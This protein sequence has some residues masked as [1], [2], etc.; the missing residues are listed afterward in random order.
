MRALQPRN[1]PFWALGLLC[2]FVLLMPTRASAASDY[3]PWY[4][5]PGNGSKLYSADVEPMN[6]SNETEM[7]GDLTCVFKDGSTLDDQEKQMLDNIIANAALVYT[8][9][10][11]WRNDDSSALNDPYVKEAVAN[12]GGF[13]D[14][15]AGMQDFLKFEQEE[16]LDKDRWVPTGDSG[17][18]SGLLGN[19]D[20]DDDQSESHYQDGA[21]KST[22]E[23][24]VARFMG[25]PVDGNRGYI[26]VDIDEE[27]VD[28]WQDVKQGQISGLLN[29]DARNPLELYEHIPQGCIVGGFDSEVSFSFGDF[30]DE[31]ADFIA[32]LLVSLPNDLTDSIYQAAYPYAL[33]FT[34]WTPHSERGDTI[35]NVSFDCAPADNKVD[36]ISTSAQC[37]NGKPLGFD[38]RRA[39]PGGGQGWYLHLAYFFQ[40]LVS[41]FY[42]LLIAVAAVLYM[43]RGN[44]DTQMNVLKIVPR[45]LLSAVLTLFAP[46]IIGGLISM[47][48]FFVLTIFSL[49]DRDS[50]GYI[51]SVLS[52]AGAASGAVEFFQIFINSVTGVLASI[53]TLMLALYA[54]FRQLVL[55]ALVVF[56]PVA[57][58]CLI[59]DAWRPHFLRYVRA[60]L[61]VV[62]LPPA[63]ALFLKLALSINPLVASPNSTFGTTLG[64]LGV[65]MILATLW[66]T[67]KMV[68]SGVSAA[69]NSKSM[70]QNLGGLA[71][72][73]AAS[74]LRPGSDATG[75]FA[76]LRRLGAGAL[77]GAAAAAALSD[78]A[79]AKMVPPEKMAAALTPG[80]G[81]AGMKAS[82][83]GGGMLDKGVSAGGA[84]KA[85]LGQKIADWQ[86]ARAEKAAR[87]EF[88]QAAL[89]PQTREMKIPEI[90]QAAHTAQTMAAADGLDFN[91]L[92][93]KRQ[94]EYWNK[95][96]GGKIER[97][98][99]G[100]YHITPDDPASGYR[101]AE[102]ALPGGDGTVAPIA[103]P[104]ES[105]G[106]NYGQIAA[107]AAVAGAAGA[108]A[109]G[110]VHS[111]RRS[112][113]SEPVSDGAPAPA[114]PPP[115]A[116]DGSVAHY[117][118]IDAA[119]RA[120]EHSEAQLAASK[121]TAEGIGRMAEQQEETRK[122]LE[123]HTRMHKEGYEE[124]GRHRRR[125]SD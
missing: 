72:G 74:R 97:R 49:D 121:E 30:F 73:A 99:D 88:G 27:N 91:K 66:M 13:R 14:G 61:I 34:F 98:D 76:S 11:E 110:A 26:N 104:I 57:A 40:W 118:S 90:A 120:R 46:F 19:L 111:A 69:Y 48:N 2:V 109:S 12:N 25:R 92:S 122:E 35:L 15:Q 93:R 47:S 100:S 114:A 7:Y 107:G 125:R 115:P 29:T 9:N 36:R 84:G 1:L 89:K 3:G 79:S 123:E 20:V 60:L 6:D 37:E 43:I 95:A 4:P 113:T 54:I 51:N 65:L 28:D 5:A 55:L 18:N 70:N 116:P 75:K 94:L 82:E 62:A 58:F 83:F 17:N 24:A 71:A 33:K 106:P 53:A 119:E 10:Y 39:E 38:K 21:N 22:D 105:D 31:P 56:A 59:I 63:C 52:N 117:E 77:G 42:M 8:G 101:P 23:D 64:M 41:G 96:A 103:P 80:G 85:A 32:G 45:V 67:S 87:K 86:Q 50:I 44:A 68:R 78:K 16:L 112:A 108:A 81:V 124:A 102:I